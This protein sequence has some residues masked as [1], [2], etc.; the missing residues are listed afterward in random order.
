MIEIDKI[1][2]KAYVEVNEIIN[3]L[4]NEEKNKIPDSLKNNILANMDKTYYFQ[5]DESKSLDEQNVLTET[6]A[7]IIAIYQRY[8]MKNNEKELWDKYNRICNGMIEQEKAKEY[9]VNNIFNKQKQTKI[10][11]EKQL[12]VV[13]KK[14]FFEKIKCKLLNMFKKK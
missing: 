13:K 6:K 5:F 7:L 11:E 4:P 2:A 1:Y 10:E 14:S 8:F 12:V 3:H 9:D